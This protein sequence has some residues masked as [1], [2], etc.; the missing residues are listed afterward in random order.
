MTQVPVLIRY[1]N[2][3]ATDKLLPIQ[4]GYRV[5]NGTLLNDSYQV[6]SMID[7]TQNRNK[8]DTKE[9]LFNLDN[10]V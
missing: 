4:F 2:Y 5:I 9:A 6:I 7:T 1:T 3:F 10:K 8:T